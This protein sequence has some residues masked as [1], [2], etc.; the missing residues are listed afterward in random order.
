MREE[1][2][3]VGGGR[4]REKREEG[5]REGGREGGVTPSQV[6]RYESRYRSRQDYALSISR[7]GSA[8]VQNGQ[9]R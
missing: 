9:T 6:S 3:G 1:E 5:E 7:V 4:E 8:C 2:R